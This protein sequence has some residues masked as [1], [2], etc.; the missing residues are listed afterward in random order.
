MK[1]FITNIPDRKK[2]CE[3][4]K[5]FFER[6]KLAIDSGFYMEA[7]LIEYAAIESRM[8]V[9]MGIIGLPC[10]QFIE[11]AKR[12]SVQISHRIHCAKTIRNSA[13]FEKTKLPQN[14]FEQLDTWIDKRNRYIHGLYKD[15]IKYSQR[16]SGAKQLSENGL[17]YCHLLYNEVNRLK[18]LK[19]N[20]PE[21]FTTDFCC[22]SSD[23]SLY[24]IKG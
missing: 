22:T 3:M 20:R 18:R 19:R 21:I 5:S 7:I 6:C 15:E 14:Y 16:M 17:K 9:L 11:D 10:N 13:P 4:H 23:C 12:K 24:N 2:Q 8:E 1:N